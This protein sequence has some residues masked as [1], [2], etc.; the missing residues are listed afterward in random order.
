MEPNQELNKQTGSL[1]QGSISGA[2]I[3]QNG[4][5]TTGLKPS[6]DVIFQDAPVKKNNKT[7]IILGFVLLALI[8]AGGVAFGVWAMMDG[9]TK[10]K[11]LEAQVDFLKEQNNK[12]SS[13]IE[14]LEKKIASTDDDEPDT[15]SDTVEKDNFFIAD[16]FNIRV[17]LPDDILIGRTGFGEN[18]YCGP[19]ISILEVI[20]DGQTLTAEDGFGYITKCPLSSMHPYAS[21]VYTYGDYNYYYESAN[22]GFDDESKDETVKVLKTI[23]EDSNNYSLEG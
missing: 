12:L 19:Y 14:G 7:G 5:V 13:E 10:T 16:E 23:F 1:E 20:K 9:D 4:E 17:N 11:Q 21:L 2:N 15:N 6:T 8:A 3:G 22:G 18:G